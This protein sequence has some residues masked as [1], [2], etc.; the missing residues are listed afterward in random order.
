MTRKEKTGNDMG[1]SNS[2]ENSIILT[3]NP[4]TIR[5]RVNK[6]GDEKKKKH[7]KQTKKKNNKSGNTWTIYQKRLIKQPHIKMSQR[8]E[9]LL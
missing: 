2:K 7:H 6:L 5:E 8:H 9:L 4:E 1:N 3:Q